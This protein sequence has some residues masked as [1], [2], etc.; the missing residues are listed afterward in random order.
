MTNDEFENLLNNPESFIL[1]FK[2]SQYEIIN[3]I[4]NIKTA[5][6]VKDIISFCNTIRTDSA[7]IIIGVDILENGEKVLIGLDKNIDDSTF[8]E[9]LKNKVI[10][11]P[12]FLYYTIQY[13]EKTFGVIEIPVKKYT[14]PISGTIKMKGI[15]PGKIYIRR[16]TSNSEALGREII[17]IDKWLHSLPHEH[18]QSES[19]PE[20]ISIILLEITSNKHPLSECIAKMLLLSERFNLSKLKE[21]CSNELKGWFNVLPE[22]EVPKQLSYRL[23]KVIFTP[24]IIEINP[25]NNFDSSRMLAEMRKMDGCF[26]QL[27]LFP[28]PISEIEKILNRLKEKPNTTLLQLSS[29]ASRAFRNDKIENLQIHIYANRDNFENIYGGIRQKLISVLLEIN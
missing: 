8:Q 4:D 12:F 18:V 24:Y 3:D 15:E 19:L 22:E 14:E 9:K 5:K 20:S 17:M 2:R 25:Y 29:S 13:N 7:F 21:F 27:F 11:I 23:N 6:F 28:Q 10:P 16:G 26:E 1:D